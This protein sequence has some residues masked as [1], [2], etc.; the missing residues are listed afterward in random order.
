MNKPAC[1]GRADALVEHAM[2]V[3]VSVCPDGVMMCIN[4]AYDAFVVAAEEELANNTN[5]LLP[6]KGKRAAESNNSG[7]GVIAVVLWVLAALVVL[8]KSMDLR[9]NLPPDLT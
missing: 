6:I 1:W 5:I 2:D 9:G 8:W 7:F 4:D 3:G